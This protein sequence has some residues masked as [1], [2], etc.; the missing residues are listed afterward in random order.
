MLRLLRGRLAQAAAAKLVDTAGNAL[1]GPDTP[2]G[3][4]GN[5]QGSVVG[6]GE[7]GGGGE[8]CPAVI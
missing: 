2:A 7:T 6:G 5:S 8:R 4:Y 3:Y 1:L